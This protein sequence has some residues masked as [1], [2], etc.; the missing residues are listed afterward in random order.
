MNPRDHKI[1]DGQVLLRCSKCFTY[2]VPADFNKCRS[3][4]DGRASK[5]R[6]CARLAGRIRN[7]PGTR[8]KSNGDLLSDEAVTERAYPDLAAERERRIENHHRRVAMEGGW[9]ASCGVYPNGKPIMSPVNRT[10]KEGEAQQ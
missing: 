6:I 9:E 3:M 2:K 10:H 1:V 5:C 4:R 7:P 8:S